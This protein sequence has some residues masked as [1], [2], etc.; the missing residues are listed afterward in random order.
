MQTQTIKDHLQS[1]Y[2]ELKEATAKRNDDAKAQIRT[3]LAH[4]DAAKAELQTRIKADNAKD[5]ADAQKAID[6]LQ[7][8]ARSAKAA[9]DAK[10]ADIQSHLKQSVA[11]AKAALDN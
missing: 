9:I 5:K 10:N 11:A 7:E 3:A 6:K 1:F 8:A 4:A 2:N